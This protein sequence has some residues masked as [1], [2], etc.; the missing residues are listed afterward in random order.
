MIPTLFF[1]IVFLV[2]W[3][4]LLAAEPLVRRS[5]AR[6]AHF[7]TRFRHRDYLPV[8]VLVMA[9]AGLAAVVGI[10][11]PTWPSWSC[12]FWRPCRY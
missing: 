11:S 7:T 9:G 5:L 1:A 8:I 3:V 2:S 6:A 12:G 4:I 10:C